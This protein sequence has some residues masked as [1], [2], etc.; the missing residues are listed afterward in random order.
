M[1]PGDLLDTVIS[2]PQ[3]DQLPTVSDEPIDGA[4]KTVDLTL[5]RTAPGGAGRVDLEPA[6]SLL[7]EFGPSADEADWSLDDGSGALDADP[8]AA[9][10][11]SVEDGEQNQPS[12]DCGRV[13][14]RSGRRSGR[15][16]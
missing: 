1:E 2:E 7:P 11:R 13:G 6:T 14:R 8:L 3:E 5:P 15:H 4:D 9:L 16:L 10:A 12:T